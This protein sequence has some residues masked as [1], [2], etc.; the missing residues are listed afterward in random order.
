MDGSFHSPA[1]QEMYI[2]SLTEVKR[3]TWEEFKAEQK[4]KESAMERAAAD[5][6]KNM[7]M[8]PPKLASSSM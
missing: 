5:E 1:F 8:R 2:K 7:R 4:A 6:E 3:Q